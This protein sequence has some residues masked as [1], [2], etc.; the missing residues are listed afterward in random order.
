MFWR[1]LSVL[2]VAAGACAVPFE[3]LVGRKATTTTSAACPTYTVGPRLNATVPAAFETTRPSSGCYPN[4]A[5]T[6]PT[7]FATAAQLK[8]WWCPETSEYGFLGFS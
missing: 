3:A 7:T 1:A 2:V 5:A 4:S 6:I 8:D